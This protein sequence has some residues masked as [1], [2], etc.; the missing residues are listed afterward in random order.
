[1]E[2]WISEVALR[3]EFWD[4]PSDEAPERLSTTR[5]ALLWRMIH[6]NNR[7]LESFLAMPD[8]EVLYVPFMAYS[9]LCGILICQAKAAWALVNSITGLDTSPHTRS[10]LSMQQKSEAHMVISAVDYQRIMETLMEKLAVITK[11]AIVE[12]RDKHVVVQFC[13]K[14]KAFAA[15][16]ATETQRRI[17]PYTGASTDCGISVRQEVL[18]E[19]N[20]WA[21]DPG[22]T[23]SGDGL[24]ADDW[25]SFGTTDFLDQ[26]IWDSVLNDF[27]GSGL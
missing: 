14:V 22:L 4:T 3:D 8:A 16:F 10:P 2:T 25:Q 12:G 5:T 13:N 6:A 20:V 19:P 21:G 9:R 23:P 24:L 11:Q 27:S 18:P 26:M 17:C 1:M 7:F 15:C